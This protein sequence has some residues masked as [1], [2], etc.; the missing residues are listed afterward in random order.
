MTH[1]SDP[2]PLH[3]SKSERHGRHFEPMLEQILLVP[4]SSRGELPLILNS[5]VQAYI[6]GEDSMPDFRR[7][8]EAFMAIPDEVVAYDEKERIRAELWRIYTEATSS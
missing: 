1:N 7:L 2:D 4:E 5:V 8:L 6:R 3:P